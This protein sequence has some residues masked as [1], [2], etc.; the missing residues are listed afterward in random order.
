MSVN[1][2]TVLVVEFQH[3]RWSFAI[4]VVSTAMAQ[5]AQSYDLLRQLSGQVLQVFLENGFEEHSESTMA[6]A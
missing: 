4:N 3:L 5:R 2:T 1:T 6:G